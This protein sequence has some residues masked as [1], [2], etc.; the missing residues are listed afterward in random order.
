MLVRAG[1]VL[2]RGVCGSASGTG[3][4]SVG[5][6]MELDEFALSSCFHEAD[7]I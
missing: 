5:A 1:S 6:R 2:V 3:V 7:A 4:V